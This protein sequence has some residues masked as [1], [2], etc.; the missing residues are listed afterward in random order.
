M[1]KHYRRMHRR[2]PPMIPNPM[3]PGLTMPHEPAHVI[4]H[5]HEH[6]EFL[7]QPP[8]WVQQHPEFHMQSQ[9]HQQQRER[10]A[11]SVIMQQV[12]KV[13]VPTTTPPPPETTTLLPP[14]FAPIAQ[15][16]RLQV[17]PDGSVQQV[18][19]SLGVAGGGGGGRV[20]RG[21]GKNRGKGRGRDRRRKQRQQQQQL[22]QQ[23][24]QQQQSPDYTQ[25]LDYETTAAPS[26]PAILSPPVQVLSQQGLQL[27]DP[28]T[29]LSFWNPGINKKKRRKKHA[30][31]RDL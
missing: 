21:R 27:V 20:G 16:Y 31:E 14:D 9:S 11:M 26:D 7:H 4:L 10:P 22:L 8:Q 25:S 6:H 1:R 13:T 18:P 23:L 5:E 28:S 15:V 3:A 24:Q 2:F 17:N 19:Q 12:T 30:Q 29:G